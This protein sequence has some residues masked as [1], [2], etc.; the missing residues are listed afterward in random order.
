MSYLR[1]FAPWLV[2]AAVSAA[3]WRF[4]A[5]AGFLAATATTLYARR[6]GQPLDGLLLDISSAAFFSVLAVVGFVDP[7]SPVAGWSAALS[8]AWLGLTAWISLAVRRPF[9][10]GIARQSTPPA[11]CG[12]TPSSTG[13]T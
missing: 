5:L 11:R 2:F 3:D 13:S 8:L 7:R 9:T 4:G 12:A 10:L 1:S 6:R